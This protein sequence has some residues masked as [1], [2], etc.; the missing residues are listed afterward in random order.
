MFEDLRAFLQALDDIG[1]L[2]RVEGAD[3][4]LEIGTITELMHEQDKGGALL[5]DRIKGYL[6]GYRVVTGFHQTPVAQ[7]LGLGLPEN[8]PDIEVVRYWKD[9]CSNYKPVP[10]IEVES[11]A[12]KENIRTT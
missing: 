5:F 3:W 7:K 10:P 11:G 12:I 8:L 4:D 1:Q 2:K 9:K 6:E